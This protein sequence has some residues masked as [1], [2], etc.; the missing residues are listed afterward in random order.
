M[1]DI[2]QCLLNDLE[3]EYIKEYNSYHEGYNETLGG[4]ARVISDEEKSNLSK[5][6]KGIPREKDVIARSVKTKRDRGWYLPHNNPMFGK[7]RKGEKA[8]NFGKSF[9][10]EH[11]KNISNTRKERSLSKGENNPM[12]GK[13]HSEKARQKIALTKIGQISPL[14]KKVQCIETRSNI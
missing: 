5:L 14:R 9:S 3:I 13:K 8:P 6:K 1:Q 10:K 2:P 4:Q 11:R 7:N 12:F